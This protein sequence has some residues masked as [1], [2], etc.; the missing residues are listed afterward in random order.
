M[1]FEGS[2]LRL[3]MLTDFNDG[4]GGRETDRLATGQGKFS[5]RVIQLLG[6][7]GFAARAKLVGIAIGPTRPVEGQRGK[8]AGQRMIR[9]SGDAPFRSESQ[10][11]MRAE[12]ADLARE[13]VDYAVQFLPVQLPVWIVQ[14]NGP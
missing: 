8:G 9:V 1:G 7:M 13:I 12:L 3:E 6:P 4:R 2:D 11:D 14:N 5:G 10:Q